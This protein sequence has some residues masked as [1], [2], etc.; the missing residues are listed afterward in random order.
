LPA[1]R[2]EDIREKETQKPLNLEARS[3]VLEVP[4][5]NPLRAVLLI[6]GMDC[7]TQKFAW[8]SQASGT[9]TPTVALKV[10]KNRSNVTASVGHTE[11]SHFLSGEVRG[12]ATEVQHQRRTWIIQVGPSTQHAITL[13]RRS[14]NHKALALSIDGSLFV[15]G[16]AYDLGCNSGGW[17]CKFQIL[18]ERVLDFEVYETS[19]QGQPLESKAHVK[20][21]LSYAHECTVRIPCEAENLRS[22][23]LTVNA[24]LHRRLPAVRRVH[25]EAKL[26]MQHE[27]LEMLYGITAPTHTN[28]ALPSAFEVGLESAVE[29]FQDVPA[30]LQAGY[31]SAAGYFN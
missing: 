3:L 29:I 14:S 19:R 9:P 2:A 4:K 21:T 30:R 31:T 6:D 13:E 10:S 20:T 27:A 1:A 28:Q 11:L 15:E 7:A 12:G 18:G 8:P 16:S 26:D 5:A 24:V 25:A 22:A 17:E 23:E